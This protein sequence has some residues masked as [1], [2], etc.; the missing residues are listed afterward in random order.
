V[1]KNPYEWLYERESQP[2]KSYVL[3]E[4]AKQLALAVEQFPPT[5]EE[6]EREDLRLRFEPLLSRPAERPRLAIVRAALTLYRWELERQLEAIDSYMRSETWR[7]QQL[8]AAEFE[9]A[10]FL[11]HYWVDQTLAFQE[12]A[13][14]KFKRQELLGLADRMQTRLVDSQSPLRR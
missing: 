4:V 13:Q 8:E 10:L 6:W 14:N 12:F 7:K 5:I 2:L 1:A 9:T 11:W 3:D